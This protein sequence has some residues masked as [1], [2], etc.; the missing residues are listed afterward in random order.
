MNVRSSGPWT[1][2]LFD[3][4]FCDDV[5][6]V[7]AGMV[8]MMMMLLLLLLLPIAT[9]SPPPAVVPVIVVGS[10]TIDAECRNGS[11]Q[12]GGTSS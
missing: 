6:V 7:P 12:R 10:Y 2:L 9:P 3:C 8:I 5:P 4:H 11:G 1:S